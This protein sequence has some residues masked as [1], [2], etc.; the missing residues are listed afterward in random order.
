MYSRNDKEDF[1]KLFTSG[2][3]NIVRKSYDIKNS[4]MPNKFYKY[5]TLNGKS[6]ERIEKD[7]CY[8]YLYLST[9]DS[10]NDP[11]DSYSIHNKE[12]LSLFNNKEI[13]INSVKK[14]F[15]DEEINNIFNSEDW[16][17]TL[18]KEVAKKASKNSESSE[19]L[20]NSIMHSIKKGVNNV[21]DIY[22]KMIKEKIRVC[23]LTTKYDNMVMW[24]SY[25]DKM[26]GACVEYDISDIEDKTIKNSIFPVIYRDKLLDI[27]L[28]I[29]TWHNLNLNN[30]IKY[31]LIKLNDWEYEDEWRVIGFEDFPNKEWFK[32]VKPRRVILGY[33]V[34]N[35]YK[36]FIK[37]IC[38]QHNIELCSAIITVNGLE[39]INL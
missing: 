20:Y 5:K 18:Y 8:D 16:L 22:N 12:E 24:W 34:E 37:S 32:F 4:F 11:F 27:T 10:L 39:L 38:K 35:E 23:S 13:Y 31:S 19:E 28:D 7:I 29:K 30:L 9:I 17:R 33:A 36:M 15:N 2:D 6:R 14:F 1:L 21:V 3:I 26:K 25:A